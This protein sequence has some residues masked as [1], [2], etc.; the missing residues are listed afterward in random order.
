MSFGL[1]LENVREE[2][3]TKM[4]NLER[5]HEKEIQ[6]LR[7]NFESQRENWISTF[8]K[9]N[10]QILEERE[11]RLVET[12]NQEKEKEIREREKKVKDEYERIRKE[13][14]SVQEARIK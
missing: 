3:D 2:Y 7:D 13:E 4:A 9:R 5:R 6:S 8:N 12:L 14:E 11:I 1:Q 10:E